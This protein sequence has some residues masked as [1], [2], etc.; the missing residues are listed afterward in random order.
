MK[1]RT[2]LAVISSA[3]LLATGAGLSGVGHAAPLAP[4]AV[5]TTEVVAA[6][7]VVSGTVQRANGKLLEN[8]SVTATHAATGEVAASALTYGGA[9]DLH[10]PA[11]SYVLAFADLGGYYAPHEL[12]E[13]LA[14]LEDVQLP[15]ETMYRPAV[16]QI[17]APVITGTPT[18][19]STLTVGD[20]AWAQDDRQ[21]SFRR[22]W[23]LDG[24]EVAQGRTL[25]V[26]TS[27]L[28]RTLTAQVT[29][30]ATGSYP[31]TGQAQDVAVPKVATR[32]S[33]VRTRL[34]ERRTAVVRVSAVGLVPGGK[35][36]VTEQGRVLGSARLERG[37][38]VVTLKRLRPGKHALVA[39]YA[40][41]ALTKPS[42][43]P[44]S[45]VTV[46]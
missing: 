31:A 7:Y 34:A 35:V 45:K 46:R 28:G 38:A 12:A 20:G 29:V 1:V 32:T 4:V 22:V 23:L 18:L 39:R 17:T 30:S 9:Y 13:P 33:I 8:I 16:L 26:D 21:L 14:V 40:G 36:T 44:R 6:E 25:V 10:L 24:T 27:H 43:S 41:S 11:G 15:V 37:K 5:P 19:G 2:G 3:A 42:K